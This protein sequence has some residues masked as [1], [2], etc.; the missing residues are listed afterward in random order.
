MASSTERIYETGAEVAIDAIA[1]DGYIVVIPQSEYGP[2]L[3][4]MSEQYKMIQHLQER[5]YKAEKILTEKGL[6]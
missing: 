5:V 4:R 6:L 3:R 2:M 1:G